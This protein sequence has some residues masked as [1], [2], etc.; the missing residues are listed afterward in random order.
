MARVHEIAVASETGAFEKGI[1]SGVVKPLE[2]AEK[3]LKG[4]GD[5]NVGKDIDRDLDGAQRATKRLKDET[6][7][8]AADIER[9]F[10]DSYRKIKNESE[11]TTS[12]V[13]SGLSEAKEEAASSGR[14]A[15]ASFGGGFEDAADFVQETLA[16]ALSG[17]GPIGAAAGIALAAVLGTALAQAQAA[18]EKLNE[19]REAAADLASEMYE[20]GG[21][22]PLQSHVEKLFQTLSQETKA[23]GTLQ[24]M[25][26]QWAD[27][28]SVLD[29]T[30]ASAK[31]VGQPLAK[32][33]DA[34]AGNDL[35]ATRRMLDAV[36]GELDRMSDWTPVWDEQYQSL[37]GYRT[38]L[39]QVIKTQEQ[40]ERI[41]A[42]VGDSAI[43]AA[44]KQEE[45]AEQ[46]ATAEEEAR[47]RIQAA[48]DSVLQSQLGAYDSMRAAAVDKATAD[49]AAFDTD[50]WLTYVEETRAAADS[51]RDNIATMQLSPAE[52]ENLLSLPEGARASIA[53]SY[54][55]AGDDGKARIRAALGDGGAGEAGSEATVSFEDAFNPEADVE[56]T[57]K[58]DTSVSEAKIATLTK[59]RQM[60]IRVKLDTSE[61]D[62]WTPPRKTGTV[63]TTVD[64]SAWSDWRVPSKTGEVIVQRREVG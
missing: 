28:G 3:A 26:D 41:Q 56:V 32:A 46:R 63:T 49:G 21:E 40:A 36:N 47:D 16:N 24:S 29:D 54:A 31:A 38:E 15:A 42:A 50:R 8:A 35:D 55:A 27:F 17:F 12:K 14:E 53:A 45:A 64:K 22:L 2:D 39:E 19:A 52:W 51:Y 11:E 20:N 30:E 1:K 7:D 10:R 48:T 13:K 25:I 5:T 33:I 9:A 59:E 6:K 4:L 57:T 58:V 62:N 18:Q 60:T 34:L 43:A 61:V 23:N 37:T 44:Q